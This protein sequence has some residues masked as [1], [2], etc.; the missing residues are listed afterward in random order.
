MGSKTINKMDMAIY[1]LYIALFKP[2]FLPETIR[3]LLKIVL[4]SIVMIYLFNHMK[5]K[6]LKNESVVFCAYV[7]I[8]GVI[9]YVLQM[10]NI[11]AA[12]DGILY[13]ICFFEV[14]ALIKYCCNRG[15][16]SRLLKCLLNI[17]FVYC[18]LSI[19]SVAIYG[20]ENNS[21]DALYFFGS[22]FS[23]SY[24]FIF[25]LALFYSLYYEK[26][27]KNLLWK[28]VFVSLI[29]ISVIFSAYVICATALVS[30][31]V[32]VVFLF[33]PEKLKRFLTSPRIAT[34]F[35]LLSAII[36]PFLGVLLNLPFVENFVVNVLHKTSNL[37]N[38]LNLYNIYLFPVIKEKLWFGHGYSNDALELASGVMWNSKLTYYANAQNGLLDFVVKFGVVGVTIFLILFYKCF[39][40]TK[41][42]RKVVGIQTLIYALILASIV[43]VTINWIFIIGIALVCWLENDN[44]VTPKN[45]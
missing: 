15:K 23:S 5:V 14:F 45:V 36:V 18:L 44:L 28:A 42:T 34:V 39:Q 31:F 29:L 38:R 35:L 20:I 40:K 27:K 8:L 26:I 11:K 7:S 12:L 25:Y 22:K 9:L 1:C 37:T 16:S 30:T 4:V 6:E 3:T 32:F 43:E 21:N 19:V 41:K 10:A 17:T 33:L 13:G 24:F 2:Y